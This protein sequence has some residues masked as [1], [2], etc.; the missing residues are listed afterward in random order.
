MDIKVFEKA[1]STVEL[2]IEVQPAE[3]ESFEKE[4]IQHL[5]HEVQLPGFRPGKAPVAMVRKHLDPTKILEATANIAIPRLYGKAVIDQKLETIGGPQIE[6]VKFA[7][8]NPLVFKATVAVMPSFTLPDYKKFR[9]EHKPIKASD[10]EVDR[11]I[12]QLQRGKATEKDVQRAAKNGDSVEI[13]FNITQN[14]VPLEHGQGH[15]HPLIIGDRAFVPGF[16]EQLVGLSAGQEKDF[17]VTFPANYA[18]SGLAGKKADVHVKM[19]KVRE[20]ILPPIDDVFAK[21]IGKFKDL[22]DLKTKLR[23][24]LDLDAKERERERYESEVLT[25]LAGKIKME[26]PDVLLQGELN[27]MARELE[28]SLVGQGANFQDYLKSI[29]KNV[30][31]LKKGWVEQAK[32]R[33]QVGLLLR[34]I[35]KD[36]QIETTQQE[37]DEELNA[38]LRQN[39]GNKEVAE[40]VKNKAY[41][42]FVKEV[43]RNR[44]TIKLLSSL[45]EGNSK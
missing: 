6:V 17:S 9:L 44:K 13:D 45:A 3:L 21:G 2:L 15:S 42:D 10:E 24:N 23:E 1:Q 40:T 39:P 27:K 38:N 34:K 8:G 31:D 30:D 4:A 18:K 7:P 12:R 32:K 26:V 5:S 41:Q 14:K 20:R 37:L 22:A 19:L 29:G 36:E 11:M 25:T 28:Q 35:A 16:E 43:I 33:I